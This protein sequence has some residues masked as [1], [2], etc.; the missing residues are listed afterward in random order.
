MLSSIKGGNKVQVPRETKAS[1]FK[2]IVVFYTSNY[3]AS[4]LDYGIDSEATER[5]NAQNEGESQS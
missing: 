4:T 3:A 5:A 1:T 2:C